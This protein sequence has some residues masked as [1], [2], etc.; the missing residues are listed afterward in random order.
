VEFQVVPSASEHVHDVDT[1]PLNVEFQ[2]DQPAVLSQPRES[3]G[4]TDENKNELSR[5]LVFQRKHSVR[6]VKSNAGVSLYSCG[7]HFVAKIGSTRQ[8]CRRDAAFVS[9]HD[10]ARGEAQS[11][12]PPL[13][14]TKIQ[15]WPEGVGGP[16]DTGARR[17]VRVHPKPPTSLLVW[18]SA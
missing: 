8:A 4:R 10:F 1:P 17:V 16:V 3:E 7:S 11:H 5:L 13:L 9:F 18:R 14:F 6:P 15:C 12:N 2:S